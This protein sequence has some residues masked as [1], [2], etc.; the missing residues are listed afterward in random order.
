MTLLILIY[1]KN[2][3]IYGKNKFYALLKKI[4]FRLKHI[5]INNYKFLFILISVYLFVVTI[6]PTINYPLMQNY[7]L[8]YFFPVLP[9]IASFILIALIY[10]FR[11]KI[12][13]KYK[14]T[15]LISLIIIFCLFGQ[16]YNLIF[17]FPNYENG[18]KT[19]KLEFFDLTKNS[20]CYIKIIDDDY[21]CDLSVFLKNSNKCIFFNDNNKFFS[22]LKK[23]NEK[24]RNLLIT[25]HSF[26]LPFIKNIY[27]NEFKVG[28]NYLGA[29]TNMY[30]YEVFEIKQLE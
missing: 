19:N 20:N 22:Y 2:V 28:F 21:I 27:R 10:I 9:F 15:A 29:I 26:Y 16:Y 11:F 24:N 7:A 5:W 13:N 6:A 4:Y 14:Y 12:L 17:L 3:L 1:K 23:N 25:N 18:I 30:N 8:R